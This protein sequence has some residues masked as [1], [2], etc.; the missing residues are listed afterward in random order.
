MWYRKIAFDSFYCSRGCQV[1]HCHHLVC[2]HGAESQ[3]SLQIP[4]LIS[5]CRVQ[6]AECRLCRVCRHPARDIDRQNDSASQFS[7]RTAAARR[8]LQKQRCSQLLSKHRV[9]YSC[10]RFLPP[11]TFMSSGFF[12]SDAC[13]D[14]RGKPVQT[15][16]IS[17]YASHS[18]TVRQLRS[19]AAAA[20]LQLWIARFACDA[21]LRRLRRIAQ[22]PW[23][24][25]QCFA[26]GGGWTRR[27]GSAC[28][29]CTAGSLD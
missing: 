12:W 10:Q 25:G 3:V 21:L 1:H 18:V 29:D 20:S 13:A 23:R 28:G 19:A 26:C 2:R 22:A 6:S 16:L 11:C 17:T 7:L 27:G 15:L 9:C 24:A 4:L 5:Y 8:C 14:A